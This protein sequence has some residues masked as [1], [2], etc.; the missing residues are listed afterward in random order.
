MTT[1]ESF[2]KFI[3]QQV[4]K[5]DSALLNDYFPTPLMIGECETYFSREDFL[6]KKYR[7]CCESVRAL[8]E[9]I[10]F[11][12]TNWPHY[13]PPDEPY[14]DLGIPEPVFT[15]KWTKL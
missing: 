5:F 10:A 2:R 4:V 14:L 3:T 9:G 8:S 11:V 12:S 7:H 13:N 1:Q 15:Q 6:E